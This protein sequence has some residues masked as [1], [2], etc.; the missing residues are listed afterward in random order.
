MYLFLYVEIQKNVHGFSPHYTH[1]H[2][3]K[4]N[5]Y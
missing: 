4:Q 5:K 2:V 3:K 1:K